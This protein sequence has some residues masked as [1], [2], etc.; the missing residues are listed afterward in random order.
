MKTDNFI[1]GAMFGIAYLGY[2]GKSLHN[3]P[4]A[5]CAA[6]VGIVALNILHRLTFEIA[7]RYSLADSKVLLIKTATIAVA[8][9]AIIAG[10][11]LTHRLGIIGIICAGAMIV[12]PLNDPFQQIYRIWNTES[13]LIINSDDSWLTNEH[14]ALI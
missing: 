2:A 13:R 1:T 14:L 12:K 7:K 4:G 5:V 8:Y 9:G 11:V 3:F 6:I 10:L